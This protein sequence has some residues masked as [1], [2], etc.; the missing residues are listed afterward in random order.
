MAYKKISQLIATDKQAHFWAGL[1]IKEL[2]SSNNTAAS[3]AA[4]W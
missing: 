1:A 2:P 4:T 3:L